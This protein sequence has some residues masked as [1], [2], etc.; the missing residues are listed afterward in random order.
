[1]ALRRNSR[2][3]PCVL[4]VEDDCATGS[5]TTGRRVRELIE[6]LGGRGIDVVEAYTFEDGTDSFAA[7]AAFHCVLI[8]WSLGA[9]DKAS[10]AAATA[11]LHQIRA[12][13]ADVPIFL[14]ADRK[15]D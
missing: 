4:C 5:T 12:R 10:H 2:F 6:E 9:N 15:I 11:L 8:D 7:N 14:L 13:R 1:M 3:R